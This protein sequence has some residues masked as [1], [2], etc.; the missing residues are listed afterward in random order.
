M[1]PTLKLDPFFDRHGGFTCETTS[2]HNGTSTLWRPGAVLNGTPDAVLVSY[3]ERSFFQ[4]NNDVTEARYHVKGYR[5]PVIAWFDNQTG[6]R[7]A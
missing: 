5:Y 3:N 2:K 6:Q 1:T 7:I 4:L